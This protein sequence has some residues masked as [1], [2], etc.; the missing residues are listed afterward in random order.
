MYDL[1]IL[2]GGPAALAAAMYAVRKGINF[3]VV[4]PDLGGKAYQGLTIPDVEAHR[5]LRPQALV[6]DYVNQLSYL[7]YT[8]VNARATGVSYAED[9]CDV[10]TVTADGSETVYAAQFVLIATGVTPRSLGVPGEREFAGRGLGYSSI[11]YSHLLH[12]KRVF[13]IGDSRR[14]VNDAREL[15]SH[16]REVLLF[17][18]FSG[19][20]HDV[21]LRELE[22]VSNI[23]LVDADRV[24][25][26]QGQKFAHSVVMADA[27]GVKSH[28]EADAFFVQL[29]PAPNSILAREVVDIDDEGRVIVDMRNRTT[30]PRIYAA[31][32]VTNV[33]FEQ[34]LVALGEGTKAALAIYEELTRVP[35]P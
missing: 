24:L 28:Y 17:F 21:H 7:T 35:M 2:G 10:D 4:S 25:E 32:D 27:D 11:S 19:R 14:T 20:Y 8:Y 15:A 31:G 30:A 29:Q 13:L 33:G 1:I 6:Q 9:H 3:L 12:G 22:A 23:R 26:F 16:A 18:R 34:I 5:A